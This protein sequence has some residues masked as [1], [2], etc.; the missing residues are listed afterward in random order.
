MVT[1]Q[2]QTEGG[3]RLWEHL[4]ADALQR[5]Y[6]AYFF[7]DN[8]GSIKLMDDDGYYNKHVDEWYGDVESFRGKSLAISKKEFWKEREQRDS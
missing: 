2:Y 8:K 3:R 1:D 5:G 6:K 4:V 7:D